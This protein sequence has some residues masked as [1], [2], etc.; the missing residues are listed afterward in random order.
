MSKILITILGCAGLLASSILP[1]SAQKTTS[2]LYPLGGIEK[3]GSEGKP[4]VASSMTRACYWGATKY[5]GK[6]VR[7]R[8]V[9]QGFR[10][11]CDFT[12]E[13]FVVNNW[14]KRSSL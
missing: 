12:N 6:L 3:M 14:G 9:K 7:V 2:Q 10:I 5:S 4:R 1:A 8:P 11:S 13:S